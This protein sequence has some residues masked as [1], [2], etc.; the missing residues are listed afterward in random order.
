M[1]QEGSRPERS[2]FDGDT[3]SASCFTG[4]GVD[5]EDIEPK[6]SDFVQ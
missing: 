3:L 2:V 4:S 1:S 6:V 5:W